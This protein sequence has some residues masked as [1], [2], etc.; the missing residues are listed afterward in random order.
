M[1]MANIRK[2][3]LVLEKAALKQEQSQG[4]SQELSPVHNQGA[5]A[6]DLALFS[7]ANRSVA[8][9]SLLYLSV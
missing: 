5:E 8:L 3:G 2:D 9:W 6:P 4:V 7:S 1:V